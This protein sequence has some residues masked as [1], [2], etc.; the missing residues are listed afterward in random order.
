MI[1]GAT[2]GRGGSPSELGSRTLAELRSGRARAL[3]PVRR[4]RW[5]RAG[6]VVLVVGAW[7]L[8]GRG[9][10]PLFLSHPSAI[11][12][13]LAQMV[14]TG[15][16]YR[17]ALASLGVLLVGLALA[18][19]LGAG[20]GLLMGRYPAVEYALDP[21]VYAFDA[22]PR[23]AL[24]PLLLLWLGVG[25]ASKVAI[26]FLSAAFPI[27]IST[28]SG[29]RDVGAQLV[30]TGRACGAREGQVFI[31]IIVP[32]ALP[33]IILGIRLAI[34]RALVGVITAEMLTAVSGLGALLVRYSSALAADRAFAL[35]LL[36]A[37]LGLALN[38][39]AVALHRRAAPWQATERAAG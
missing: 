15:E 14:S 12:R 29:V 18:L 1:D 16:L 10:S 4:A 2:A 20:L 27:L 34:G 39:A 37:L 35:V 28:F 8:V 31:K 36:L 24:I 38:E 26:V 22:T 17:P 6:A 13:A 11:A 5:V 32:A 30:D 7:E 19:V 9:A 33:F 3:G 21:Y 23:I 25:T